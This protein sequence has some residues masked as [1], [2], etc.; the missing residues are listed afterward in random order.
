[1]SPLPIPQECLHFT[2][3]LL[4]AYFHGNEQHKG[5]ELSVTSRKMLH[6]CSV[7]GRMVHTWATG[8][9]TTQTW[10]ATAQAQT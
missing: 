7:R 9:V 5:M 4:K 6:Q 8:P 2:V 3:S 10:Q 1:M